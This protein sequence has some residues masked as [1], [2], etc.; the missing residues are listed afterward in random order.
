[1]ASCSVSTLSI[2]CYA[3]EIGPNHQVN[4]CILI[5]CLQDNEKDSKWIHIIQAVAQCTNT[6]SGYITCSTCASKN[7][8]AISYLQLEHNH[9][10]ILIL[11]S[12][13]VPSSPHTKWYHS[14]H[15]SQ[16]TI[17]SP[18]LGRWHTHI[19][20]EAGCEWFAWLYNTFVKMERSHSFILKALK[21]VRSQLWVVIVS[22][23]CGRL[24]MLVCQINPVC[25]SHLQFLYEVTLR[26][27]WV[28]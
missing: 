2:R 1:M 25:A 9:V 21:V 10:P 4:E 3:S 26:L 13:Q 6:C 27:I 15:W 11:S 18:Q 5:A 23:C 8:E 12:K 16:L 17:L 7:S 28:S 22:L 14:L 20:L 19:D 24:T